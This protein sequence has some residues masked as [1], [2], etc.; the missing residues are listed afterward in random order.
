MVSS[1]GSQLMLAN[2]GK[3]GVFRASMTS[4]AFIIRDKFK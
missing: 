4:L 2:E 3:F 1:L